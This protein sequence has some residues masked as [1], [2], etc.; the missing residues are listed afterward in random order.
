MATDRRRQGFTVIELLLAMAFL[1]FMLVFVVGATT[2]LLRTYNKGLTIKQINQSGRDI[3]ETIKRDLAASKT[4]T[5]IPAAQRLCTDQAAYIWNTT[6]ASPN[7]YSGS[8]STTPL[9]LVRT[10]DSSF[11]SQACTLSGGRY[12]AIPKVSV[13]ELLSAQASVETLGLTINSDRKLATLQLDLGSSGLSAPV[14]DA[15]SGR[16]VCTGDINGQFCA[17]ASFVTTIYAPNGG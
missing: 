2:Q 6:T 7:Q 8:D 9:Y 3:S 14:F 5:F 12:P 15:V 11:L 13:S 17:T 1:G 16:Y 10:S 4:I